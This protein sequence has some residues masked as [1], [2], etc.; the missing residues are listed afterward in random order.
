MLKQNTF[1]TPK[2]KLEN[3]VYSEKMAMLFLGRACGDQGW[4]KP[5][6]VFSA[7]FF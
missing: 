4:A 1:L 5:N 3:K 6:L 2:S 7:I